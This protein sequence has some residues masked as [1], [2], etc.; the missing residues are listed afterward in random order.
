MSVQRTILALSATLALIGTTSAQESPIRLAA[1]NI[2]AQP[3]E[4]ALNEFAQQANCQ[5]LFQSDVVAKRTAPPLEG[6]LAPEAA[7]RVL[8]QDSGLEYQF[9]N[10]KTVAIRTAHA[11]A[12]P[13]DNRVSAD[14]SATAAAEKSE[15]PLAQAPNRLRVAQTANQT[16]TT[17]NDGATQQSGD[18]R[19]I[20]QITITGTHIRGVE[21]STVPL[22]VLDAAYIESTGFSTTARLIE[23]LPQN[24]AL[25][26]QSGVQ[27]PGV[28]FG[29]HQGT[30]INLRGIGE[31]TT[32][33]LING[34]RLAPGFASAAVDISA[35]PLSAIERV[36]VVLD[37]ASALYGSDAVG[38]VVNFILKRDFQG[39]ETRLR[40]GW[41]DGSV[42][43]YQVSQLLGTAWQ[44][45]NA[46]LSLDYYKR[47]LMLAR[48]RDFVP[49]ESLI[50]SLLPKD[51][52]VSAV[53]SGQQRLN[54]RLKA[55]A[56]AIYTQRDSFNIGDRILPGQ[57][58]FSYD[59][60]NPQL[61]AAAGVE[62]RVGGDWRVNVD[63]TYAR[64]SME[65]FSSQTQRVFDTRF[66]LKGVEAK[67]D[68]TVL[69]LPGGKLRAAVGA[70]WRTEA[71][72]SFNKLITT[73][74]ISGNVDEEQIV[75][76]AFGQVHV[77]IVG[78]DNA[79]TGIRALELS[80]A[81]RYDDYSR[82]GSSFDPQVGLTW[83]PIAGI[84]LR[85]S[86]GSSFKAPNLR[87]F[88][89]GN[90]ISFSFT[91][92]DPNPPGF[93][94]QMMLLGTVGSGLTPQ[95]SDNT[96]FGVEFTPPSIPGLR[97]GMNFYRIEYKDRITVPPNP[98]I[99]P[100]ILANPDAYGSLF[101]RNPSAALVNE[102]IAFGVQGSGFFGFD[103][104]FMPIAPEDFDPSIVDVLIDGRTRNL[105]ETNTSGWDIS[106][107]YR[108]D[109]G[110]GAITL[111]IDGTDIRKMDQKVTPTSESHDFVST[112]FNPVGRRA[113]A[114]IAWQAGPW[115][116]NTFINYTD[117]YT[118][119]RTTPSVPISSFTTV[120]ARLV[121]DFRARFASGVLSGVTL[122]AI[123]QNLFDRDPPA[124]RVLI[125]GGFDQGFDSTNANPL[126]RF[127]AVEVTK[128]W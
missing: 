123:A 32:L 115:A 21:N 101:V 92:L 88:D 27:T 84:S 113:R 120:D 5:L 90:N 127:L 118:D 94:Y 69:D 82:S 36:E 68:G 3:L 87:D 43:E 65:N 34:H 22:L 78:R 45:G 37:G 49:P 26:N 20:A 72:R 96:S 119:D 35:L 95:E 74:V 83:S 73:D 29:N 17:Q 61:T 47:D 126:G 51:K 54:D 125:A 85:A 13:T 25:A 8:L 71:Y 18:A 102:A 110:A 99:A 67:A 111:G 46:M 31:G 40:S 50:G 93:S 33:V 7:L 41:A 60:D 91:N 98:I 121:Y 64:N 80:V 6:R 112:I 23:S 76:S 105:S 63:G 77:P 128:T 116:A 79:V 39:A 114:L 16:Q 89:P 42:N 14:T 9:I 124:T 97:F 108:L 19:D 12:Q 30:S 59:T 24:F 103:D 106:V 15:R 11:A 57:Q 117:S 62:V 28:T 10:T 81:G 66:E 55:F 56:D 1:F 122:S 58:P 2:E 53:F 104:S 52:N 48:E 38:G 109:V 107:Q 86:H 44:S 100:T 70:E 4:D 75:R